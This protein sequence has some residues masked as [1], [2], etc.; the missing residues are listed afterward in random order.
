LTKTVPTVDWKTSGR[1]SLNVSA[2]AGP[3]ELMFEAIPAPNKHDIAS[4]AHSLHTYGYGIRSHH[5]I[6]RLV[7]G[8]IGRCGLLI[9]SLEDNCSRSRAAAV[10]LCSIQIHEPNRADTAFDTCQ[11]TTIPSSKSYNELKTM[12]M[13]RRHSGRE[14]RRADGERSVRATTQPSCACLHPR[15]VWFVLTT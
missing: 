2:M 15:D 10:V 8:K 6:Y 7:F 13:M 11:H 12:R 14:A 9:N 4:T 1:N 3:P 5:G